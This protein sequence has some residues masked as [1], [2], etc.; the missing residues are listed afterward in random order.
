MHHGLE[1]ITIL[2][3]PSGGLIAIDRCKI[4]PRCRKGIETAKSVKSSYWIDIRHANISLYTCSSTGN[5]T[6]STLIFQ[7]ACDRHSNDTTS[8]QPFDHSFLFFF[9]FFFFFLPFAS[10]FSPLFVRLSMARA[11]NEK[12]FDRR[13]KHPVKLYFGNLQAKEVCYDQ[14]LQFQTRKNVMIITQFLLHSYDKYLV[15]SRKLH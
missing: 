9:Y 12:Q 11:R 6:H 3:Y 15:I 4:S 8:H 10:L 13:S 1:K 5:S 2:N 14:Q 7:L